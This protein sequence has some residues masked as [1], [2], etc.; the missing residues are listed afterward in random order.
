MSME[1]NFSPLNFLKPRDR[2]RE[3]SAIESY[4]KIR[5]TSFY[6]FPPAERISKKKN[7]TCNKREFYCFSFYVE[8]CLR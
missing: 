4:K 2:E 5:F 3:N 6:A 8:L 7:Q 1:I